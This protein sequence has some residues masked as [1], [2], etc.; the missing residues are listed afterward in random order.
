MWM[1]SKPPR[2]PKPTVHVPQTLP[3]GGPEDLAVLVAESQ[4]LGRVEDGIKQQRR[5]IRQK[6]DAILAGR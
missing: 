3:Q 1:W 4:R 2:T 6:I 5:E